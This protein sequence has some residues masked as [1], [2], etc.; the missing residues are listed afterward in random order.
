[1]VYIVYTVERLRSQYELRYGGWIG[2]AGGVHLGL[3]L[4]ATATLTHI[5]LPHHRVGVEGAR[6]IARGLRHN[7][8]VTYV[9]LRSNNVF[10]AGA[11]AFAKMLRKGANETLRTLCLDANRIGE[12]GAVKLGEALLGNYYLTKLTLEHND[13]AKKRVDLVAADLAAVDSAAVDQHQP[14]R[15]SGI[16]ALATAVARRVGRP[17]SI[18]PRPPSDPTKRQQQQATN[19]RKERGGPRYRPR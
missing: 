11:A 12:E 14:P 13:F 5:A 3:C 16:R 10:D 1:M 9:D 7:R 2:P 8:S 19:H 6:A 17:L 4:P 15:G 18:F